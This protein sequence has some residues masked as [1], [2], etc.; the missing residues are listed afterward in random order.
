ML[1]LN[2]DDVHSLNNS[3]LGDFVDY[4]YSIEFEIKNTTD[5]D[6]SASYPDINLGID[7]EGW[8]RTKLYDKRNYFNFPIVNFPFIYSNNPAAPGGG[9]Y[10]YIFQLIRHSRPCGS[11]H[12][13]LDRGLL[14][15]G[16]LQNQEFLLVKLR[17]S[18]R[19][20]YSR[21][22]D[23]VNRYRI[24]MSQMATDM[25]DMSKTHPSPFLIHDLSP[26]L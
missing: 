11:Y 18:L 23:L 16:K 3:T 13:F 25:F 14:L 20:F 5:T 1:V 15:T 9:V 26:G 4:I 17:S 21:H 19:K 7:N 2:R 12:D 6:M 8:L 24:S 22:H 10:I